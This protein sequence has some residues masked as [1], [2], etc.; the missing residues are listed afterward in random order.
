[1]SID[2]L[3]TND[4]ALLALAFLIVAVLY[5]LVGH[6]GGSG[7]L[8]VMALY[9]ILPADLRPIALALN[10][11]VSSIGLVRFAKVRAFEIK[12]FWPFVVTSIPCAFIGGYIELDPTIY[13]IAL[14][15]ILLFSAYRLFMHLPTQGEKT[16][17][18]PLFA[19]LVCG[20]VIGLLSGV[21]GVGG[22]IFLSPILLLMGWATARQTAGISAGFILVNS[23]AGLAGIFAA[24]IQDGTTLP[25]SNVSIIIFAAAV[26]MGGLVGS[27]IGS[28]KLGHI[29]LRRVLAVVLVLAAV[30]MFFPS[31]SQSA[32]E[33]AN[34]T[35]D[36]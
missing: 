31:T 12:I 19:A 21:I 29:S 18:L 11:L 32:P 36:S 6:G 26:V 16:N 8:A 35:S 28:K 22:G 15:V 27:S 1:M 10:V 2:Q 33:S 23:L 3:A 20:S 5:S 24:S 7:Y 34:E 4:I 9:G 14:G 17:S 13:K 25:F 30:K